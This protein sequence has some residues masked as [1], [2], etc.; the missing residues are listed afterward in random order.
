[1]HEGV[2]EEG[3]EGEDVVGHKED[4]HPQQPALSV[5]CWAMRLV[6]TPNHLLELEGQAEG[7]GIRG[8]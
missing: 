8:G 1:M 5:L 6:C 4:R 3:Q 2:D 7:R